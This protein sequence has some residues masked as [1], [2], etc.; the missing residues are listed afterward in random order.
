MPTSCWN[1]DSATPTSTTR[2]P[3]ENSGASSSMAFTSSGSAER[4]SSLRASSRRP[5]LTSQLGDSGSE[6]LR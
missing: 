3:K 2:L 4:A 1:T 5:F 6:K